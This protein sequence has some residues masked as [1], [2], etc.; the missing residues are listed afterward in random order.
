MW[1][2]YLSTNHVQHSFGQYLCPVSG[3][4]S[5]LVAL[6]F[7]HN[8]PTRESL[9]ECVT[10]LLTWFVKNCTHLYGNKFLVYSLLHIAD[11]VR[12]VNA[13][14]DEVSAFK[15]ENYLDIEEICMITILS[16][17]ASGRRYTGM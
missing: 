8:V 6:Y 5:L 10:N 16:N 9:L 13:S 12:F 11:D 15:F 3:L 14:L 4:N 7:G 17:R 1:M 2:V